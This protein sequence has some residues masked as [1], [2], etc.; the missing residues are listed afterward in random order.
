[1]GEDAYRY[2]QVSNSRLSREFTE[3]SQNPELI[4]GGMLTLVLPENRRF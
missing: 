2:T 3:D 1:M 4:V